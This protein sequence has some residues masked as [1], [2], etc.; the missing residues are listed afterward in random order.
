MTIPDEAMYSC[1][2]PYELWRVMAYPFAYSERDLLDLFK[3]SNYILKEVYVEITINHRS[4]KSYCSMFCVL[5]DN[6][7]GN[8]NNIC[9]VGY[10]RQF[11]TI[12]GLQTYCQ[13]HRCMKCSKYLTIVDLY[14]QFPLATNPFTTYTFI[15]THGDLINTVHS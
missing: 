13:F 4:K 14:T 6:N 2:I 11:L 3:N 7:H 1:V 9:L 5:N 8:I 10:H 15:P 12:M